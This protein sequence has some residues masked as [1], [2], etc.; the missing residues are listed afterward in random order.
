MRQIEKR[1]Q[2]YVQ[3][4]IQDGLLAG[5]GFHNDRDAKI[6]VADLVVGIEKAEALQLTHNEFKDPDPQ[7]AGGRVVWM[8]D[9]IETTPIFLAQP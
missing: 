3:P 9:Q 1:P 6:F 4:D 2:V 7:N 8:S 5:M